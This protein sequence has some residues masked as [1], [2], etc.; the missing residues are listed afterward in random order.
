MFGFCEFHNSDFVSHR[1][2]QYILDEQWMG[3]SPLCGR[4]RLCD[5]EANS[6]LWL[7]LFLMPFGIKFVSTDVNDLFPHWCDDEVTVTVRAAPR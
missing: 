6:I 1:Y 2:S 3:R 5:M 4:I 7:Q